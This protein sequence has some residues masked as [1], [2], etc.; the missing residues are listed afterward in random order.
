MKDKLA[1][2]LG[3]SRRAG[4]ACCGF[5]AAAELIRC[6]RAKLVLLAADL[7]PKTEKELRFAG[8]D[9]AADIRRIPLEKA[10][11]GKALGLGRDVGVYATDDEGFAAAMKRHI[12][13]DLEEDDTI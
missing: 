7:S 8:R 12:G 4:H 9:K 10:D 13:H 6:G 2:L 5:D 1:G 11:I 3:L